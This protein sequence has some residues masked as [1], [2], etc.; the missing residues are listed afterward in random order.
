VTATGCYDA[1]GRRADGGLRRGVFPRHSQGMN[2]AFAPADER[3]EQGAELADAAERLQAL[4]IH[5]RGGGPAIVMVPRDSAGDEARA[6][7]QLSDGPH[8]PPARIVTSRFSRA[9][10][11]ELMDA[12]SLRDWS[13]AAA[14][15]KYGFGY[16]AAADVVS[17]TTSAPEA[18][19]RLIAERFGD[20][21]HVEYG[22]G[23]GRT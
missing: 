9:E 3:P 20:R 13:P 17:I 12:I 18:E 10:V 4:G 19:R 22:D 15:Y 11:R 14:G 23:P 8:H 5:R 2:D 16:D 1:T 21:V 6:L 7:G